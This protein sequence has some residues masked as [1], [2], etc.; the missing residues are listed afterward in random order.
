MDHTITVAPGAEFPVQ[1]GGD[2]V[3][4]KFA[5]RDIKVIIQNSPR[6]MRA[7]SK[8]RPAGGFEAG[9]VIVQ[10]LDPVN[11][12]AVVLTI[13]VGDF[14]DQ[15]IHGEVTVNPG[16]RGRD[17]VFIDDTRSTVRLSAA[18]GNITP[19]EY[20]AA[21]LI[22]NKGVSGL[23]AAHVTAL[24]DGRVLVSHD[25]DA[26]ALFRQWPNGEPEQLPTA[27]G[28]GA[29]VQVGPLLYIPDAENAPGHGYRLV[30]NV[31]DAATLELRRRFVTDAPWVNKASGNPLV[32]CMAYAEN[33]L[34]ISNAQERIDVVGLDGGH[35]KVIDLG[36]T[37]IDFVRGLVVRGGLVHAIGGSGTVNK[38]AVIDPVTMALVDLGKAKLPGINVSV[39]G[40]ALTV[41]DTL[42]IGKNNGVDEYAL[43]DVT[44]S[45][46]G[47]VSACAG[48]GRF[49]AGQ[50]DTIAELY[51]QR[52]ENGR[53]L[54]SGQLLRAVLEI[55]A[56]RYMPNDYLDY[57]YAVKADNLN[58]ISPRVIDAGGQ[59]FAAAGIADDAAG[60]FP[61]TIEITL[62][63]G[64]L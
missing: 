11:P 42:L 7:G 26:W 1:A 5:D 56:G 38:M 53:V 43:D 2:F 61:Q 13:G 8:W 27:L 23:I 9:D 64:L 31:Y 20:M 54:A 14:D 29:G 45:A 47:S 15:I 50:V 4:C 33:R 34:F 18:F 57:I 59:S 28:T 48:S 25:S 30:V 55:Y 58:G 62:R 35:L 3:F 24:D 60:T 37:N 39:A 63:E 44:I 21:G 6:T 52:L 22:V 36:G 17:G 46:S 32:E 10:N 19:R 49:K 16:I 51:T 41:R 12:V 40:A